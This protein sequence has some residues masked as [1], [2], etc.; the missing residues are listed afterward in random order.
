MGSPIIHQKS[1]FP[2]KLEEPLLTAMLSPTLMSRAHPAAPHAGLTCLH[3]PG[4]MEEQT[5]PSRATQMKASEPIN[6]AILQNIFKI[7]FALY[8]S[9]QYAQYMLN[10]YEYTLLF[11]FFE[12]VRSIFFFLI[13]VKL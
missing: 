3:G 2:R 11:L 12:N 6:R 1:D 13:S 5:P 8:Y 7:T 10:V 4:L 9:N